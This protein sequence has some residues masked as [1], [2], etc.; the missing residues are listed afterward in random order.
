[1]SMYKKYWGDVPGAMAWLHYAVVSGAV[2]GGLVHAGLVRGLVAVPVW[3]ASII[4]MVPICAA[5]DLDK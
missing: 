1:M 4:V 5:W 3:L 2:A